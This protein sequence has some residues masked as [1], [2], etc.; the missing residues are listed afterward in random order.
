MN[1]AEWH[2]GDY[3]EA[4][5]HLSL[6]EDGA[7]SRMLR[8]YYATEEPLPGEKREI[9]RLISARSKDEREAVDAVLADFFTLEPDGKYH[10]ARADAEIAKYHAKQGDREAKR[11]NERGRQH[12]A[13]ERRKALF[14][15]LRERGIVPDFDATTAQLEAEL[16]R[17]TTG[18][19]HAD[20]TP[21]VTRTD[22]ATTNHQPPVTNHQSPDLK[23]N[24]G[25]PSTDIPSATTAE[26]ALL[27]GKFAAEL[28]GEG[29]SVTPTNPICQA[30]A[31][32]GFTLS[33]LLAAVEVARVHKPLPELIPA[34]Y[35]D[36]VLRNPSNARGL[37]RTEKRAR[38]SAGLGTKQ[39]KQGATYDSTATRTD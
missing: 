2:L 25:K 16:S 32:D 6:I 17:V 23:P 12:R 37:S 22:T 15:Q 13:R 21:P 14:D 8:K 9:Y 39:P 27:P 35:L 11:E 28:R 18:A 5:A 24:T 29:V 4:T 33:D 20:V 34:K 36:K 38:T 1:Y 26:A 10:Q 19:R 3:A 30:W 7:Y 31:T